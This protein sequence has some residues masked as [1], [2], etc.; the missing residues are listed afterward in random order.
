MAKRSNYH[1]PKQPQIP[2]SFLNLS[3]RLTPLKF[4]SPF[5][6]AT[7]SAGIPST[8][9]N[10][11]WL[12]RKCKENQKPIPI[13]TVSGIGE[14]EILGILVL[15]TKALLLVQCVREVSILV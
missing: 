12:L 14:N 2:S 15:D 6:I 9:P 8:L 13:R 10:A 7:K 4:N 3:S 1:Q 5:P 11:V